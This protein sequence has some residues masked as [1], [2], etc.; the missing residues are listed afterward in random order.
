MKKI[1]VAD[2]IEDGVIVLIPDDGTEPVELKAEDYPQIKV[3]DAVVFE[4]GKVRPAVP[5]EHEDKR[6]EN[7]E[8]LNRLFKK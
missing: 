5:G 3:N 1:C 8:R 6:E 4:N 7:K 2:R